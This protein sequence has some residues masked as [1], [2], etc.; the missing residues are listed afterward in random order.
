MHHCT[1]VSYNANKS[2][3]MYNQPQKKPT[4]DLK[5]RECNHY[6]VLYLGGKPQ[7]HV[8]CYPL[9]YNYVG[10]REVFHL[11]LFGHLMK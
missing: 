6:Q 8:H 9:K 4:L 2:H 3:F 11:K 5:I 10:W 7:F 1:E